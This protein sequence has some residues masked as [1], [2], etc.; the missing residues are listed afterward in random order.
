MEI[1]TPWKLVYTENQT[2]PS[3]EPDNPWIDSS[4]CGQ[5]KA[6]QNP[7]KQQFSHR[8]IGGVSDLHRE[9]SDKPCPPPNT[10][11]FRNVH[12]VTYFLYLLSFLMLAKTEAPGERS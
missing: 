9:Q 7:L 1:F 2:F 3:E 12:A 4:P 11:K 10:S 8:N 5:Q 6:D